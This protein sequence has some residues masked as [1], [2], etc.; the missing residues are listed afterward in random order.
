[1]TPFCQNGK[2]DATSSVYIVRTHNSSYEVTQV[3]SPF[4]YFHFFH[5]CGFG[6]TRALQ[7]APA[8]NVI[9]RPIRTRIMSPPLKFIEFGTLS[10]RPTLHICINNA[11][12]RLVRAQ[13]VE[14]T[15][16]QTPAERIRARHPR[17]ARPACAGSPF[18]RLEQSRANMLAADRLQMLLCSANSTRNFS[19]HTCTVER[20]AVDN[21]TGKVGGGVLH[22]LLALVI[23]HASLSRRSIVP[24]PNRETPNIW[25][26][27]TFFSPYITHPVEFVLLVLPLPVAPSA[28]TI[29]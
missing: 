22:L 13:S 18:V 21:N 28:A 24:T 2:G 6:L 1:M 10:S 3:S 23:G 15:Y 26:L 9:L 8:A 25:A 5:V 17:P 4:T 20:S 7:S 14:P 12:F 19:S 27:F 29:F 16:T 11:F